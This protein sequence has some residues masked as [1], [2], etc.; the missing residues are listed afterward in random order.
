[1]LKRTSNP[2]QRF[3]QMARKKRKGEVVAEKAGRSP[4]A[5]ALAS[6]HPISSAT[7]GALPDAWQTT[8][9]LIQRLYLNTTLYDQLGVLGQTKRS[10]SKLR[11]DDLGNEDL[12]RR[13]RHVIGVFVSV[14]LDPACEPLRRS[15]IGILQTCAKTAM[16]WTSDACTE[17]AV[18]TLQSIS[19]QPRPRRCPRCHSRGNDWYPP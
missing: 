2:R 8:E 7:S 4:A 9:D 12:A 1:M 6:L 16:M 15:T 10:I 5:V 3:V 13:V 19:G 17:A 11:V 18:S 14:Y